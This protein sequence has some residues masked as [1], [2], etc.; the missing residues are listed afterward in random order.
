MTNLAAQLPVPPLSTAR[1]SAE[2]AQAR[3]ASA[4]KGSKHPSAQVAVAAVS[5]A[6]ERLASVIA[7]LDQAAEEIAAYNERL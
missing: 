6:T 1:H 5:A 3:L 2:E 4:W 7:A